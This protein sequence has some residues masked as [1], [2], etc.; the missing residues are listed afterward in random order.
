MSTEKLCIVQYDDRSDE[1]LGIMKRLMHRNQSIC[2]LSENCEYRRYAHPATNRPVYWEKVLAVK[3][4]MERN[5]HC[6]TV[7]YLDSDA[8]INSEAVDDIFQVHDDKH[9]LYTNDYNWPLDPFHHFRSGSKF[10]AGVFAVR[11]TPIGRKIMQNWSD[12]YDASYWKKTDQ[13]WKC[14]VNS[15]DCWWSSTA[16]EQGMFLKTSLH[17]KRNLQFVPAYQFNN[18]KCDRLEDMKKADVC[19]FY[20]S[21]KK[22]IPEF[23]SKRFQHASNAEAGNAS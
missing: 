4:H 23:L 17:D 13:N 20:G 15:P 7:A 18:N 5:P 16:Y 10:N 14:A 8:V 22:N 12:G 9:F 1:K 19:H 6:S 21:S 3:D 11:N 2:E